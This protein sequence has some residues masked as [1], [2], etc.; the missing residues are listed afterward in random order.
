MNNHKFY[1]DLKIQKLISKM[2][3]PCL[4]FD[5]WQIFDFMNNHDITD[6]NY[7]SVGQK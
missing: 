3:K 2:S 1:K 7:T 6:V 5:S 4:I